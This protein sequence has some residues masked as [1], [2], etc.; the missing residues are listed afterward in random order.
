MFTGVSTTDFA[1]G[2]GGSRRRSGIR[3]AITDLA[4]GGGS[5]AIYF[6]QEMSA[7]LY[8]TPQGVN[9]YIAHGRGHFS[10]HIAEAILFYIAHSS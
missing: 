8:G 4:G 5:G 7:S 1:S 9:F 2:G 3:S 6:M 10:A